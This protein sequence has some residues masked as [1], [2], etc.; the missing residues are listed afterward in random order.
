MIVYSIS[1]QM[2][3]LFQIFLIFILKEAH[4]C[5]VKTE[6]EERICIYVCVSGLTAFG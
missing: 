4:F 1:N 5:K 2:I 3:C 6:R